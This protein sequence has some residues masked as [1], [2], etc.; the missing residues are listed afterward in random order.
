MVYWFMWTRLRPFEADVA[1]QPFSRL[2]EDIA[3][4]GHRPFTS[5]LPSS[6]D[7]L[8]RAMWAADPTKRPSVAIV[9]RRM[10]HC[11]AV[12]NIVSSPLT[13]CVLTRWKP[14]QERGL[15]NV[16]HELSGSGD[17]RGEGGGGEASEEKKSPNPQL[18]NLVGKGSGKRVPMRAS[19]R[20]QQK[21]GLLDD[22]DS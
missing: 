14:G 21:R 20:Q 12:H 22:A 2:L 1:R 6:L 4:H 17:E 15:L 18:L 16:Q 9:V 7:T 11:T 5:H 8:L 3:F 13:A 19:G 10:I